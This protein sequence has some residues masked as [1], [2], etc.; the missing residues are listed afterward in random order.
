MFVDFLVKPLAEFS[1]GSVK[2]REKQLGYKL[3]LNNLF[4][5]WIDG[6]MIYDMSSVWKKANMDAI[7]VNYFTIGAVKNGK[8][9]RFDPMSPYYQSWLGGY[10]VRFANP[11]KWTVENHYKLADADQKNW[12]RIYGDKNQYV[13]IDYKNAKEVGDIKISGY[14]GK[15]YQGGIWSDTD[16]GAQS[17]NFILQILMKGFAYFMNKSNKKLSVKG[18]NFIPKWI[19]NSLLDSYQKIYLEGYCAIIEIDNLTKAVLYVNGAKYT[20]KNEKIYDTFKEQKQE[21]RK[22]ISSVEIWRI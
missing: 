4:P 18:E 8:S 2:R 14:S 7:G 10:I 6:T 3:V 15:L 22:I 5:H 11:Q 20:D 17:D 19:Q 9:T 13:E 16:V 21:L 1:F 12:L